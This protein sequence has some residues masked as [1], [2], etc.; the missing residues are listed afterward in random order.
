MKNILKKCVGFISV[1][2]LTIALSTVAFASS[3]QL[4]FYFEH[5]L[6]GPTRYFDG[7]NIAFESTPSTYPSEKHPNAKPTDNLYTATLYR[8]KGWFV[9]DEIGTAILNRDSY[10]KAL[11]S[12]IGPGNYYI[13]FKKE[14]DRMA[15]AD[16]NARMYNY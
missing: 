16:D 6:K 10:G 15:V 7:Q 1:A 2:T 14:Q 4:F 9:K 3:Y 12:N 13:Y 5:E 8:D 11:W